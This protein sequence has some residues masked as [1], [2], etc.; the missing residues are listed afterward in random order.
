[1]SIELCFAPKLLWTT[2]QL[3]QG[4]E[5]SCTSCGGRNF[6]VPSS[7]HW[8]DSSTKIPVPIEPSMEPLEH[9]VSCADWAING[10]PKH[11]D[12]LGWSSHHL[13]TQV[14]RFY[15]A[16]SIG[17][18]AIH[19]CADRATLGAIRAPRFTV[20]IEASTESSVPI[21]TV[22]I[23]PPLELFKHPDLLWR[24]MHQ[25]IHSSHEPLHPPRVSHRAIVIWDSSLQ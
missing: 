12:F 15:W 10:A 24:S 2:G 23:E 19:Q 13:N 3:V 20:A 14:S 21:I 5:H 22:P 7:R 9:Q 18:R 16:D 11:P 4:S 25:V 1:M 6:T 8:I 17:L